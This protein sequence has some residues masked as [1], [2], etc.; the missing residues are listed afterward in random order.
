MSSIRIIQTKTTSEVNHF[1]RSV[2]QIIKSYKWHLLAT[3]LWLLILNLALY[4]EYYAV[5]GYTEQFFDDFTGALSGNRPSFVTYPEMRFSYIL[6]TIS[7]AILVGVILTAGTRLVKDLVGETREKVQS[8]TKTKSI[9][10]HSENHVVVAGLGRLG[11]QLAKLLH[12]AGLTVIGVDKNPDK[13]YFPLEKEE[14]GWVKFPKRVKLEHEQ[15]KNQIPGILARDSDDLTALELVNID[16]AL[17]LCLM[18]TNFESNMLTLMS[19]KAEH[20]KLRIIARANDDHEMS[21]YNSLNVINIEPKTHG[22]EEIFYMLRHS[23]ATIKKIWGYVQ[24][25]NV[26][27]LLDDLEDAKFNIERYRR[28]QV[29]PQINFI[30]LTLKNPDIQDEDMRKKLDTI[31]SNY[32]EKLDALRAK[33]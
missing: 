31:K 23:N 13:I 20:P 22:A 2:F 28:W 10:Q 11:Q 32:F 7:P 3:L 15:Y 1:I 19:V 26:S 24:Q 18:S 27:K 17:V 8:A 14:Y 16:K 30:Q 33:N 25:E 5:H 21:I 4:I 6:I 12:D 9:I 29:A